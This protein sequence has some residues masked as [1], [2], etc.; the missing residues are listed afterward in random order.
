M[1]MARL[2]VVPLLHLLSLVVIPSGAATGSEQN[3]HNVT[4][5]RQ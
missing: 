2:R 3:H 1:G 4:W 5:L